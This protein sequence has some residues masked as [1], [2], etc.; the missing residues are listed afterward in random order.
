VEL[1]RNAS[2]SL[3]QHFGLVAAYVFGGVVMS[4][5]ASAVGVYIDYRFPDWKEPPTPTAVHAIRV[6]MFVVLSALSALMQTIIFSRIGREIDRP[7]WK[8]RDDRE[9]L[10]RFYMMW[11]EMNLIVNTVLWLSN[12]YLG[13]EMLQALNL[14][15]FMLGLFGVIVLVPFGSALM[16]H[17]RFSWSTLSEGLAPIGK[18]F[19]QV[20]P[21]FLLT[22]LQVIILI[23]VSISSNP[24][25]GELRS[26]ASRFA[27]SAMFNGAIAYLDCVVF[28]AVWLVCKE[29]RDSP[30]ELDLDF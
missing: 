20:A 6:A 14:M 16:F 17:G 11:F 15:M 28:A 19:M 5:L 9:A 8:V 18:R 22:F 12:V 24:E 21:V 3:K 26:T 2:D 29:D 25:A 30:D 13:S 10:Q 27:T 4:L 1:L 23:G 7:L